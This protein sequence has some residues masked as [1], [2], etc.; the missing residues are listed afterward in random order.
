MEKIEKFETWTPFIF[1]RYPYLA[2]NEWKKKLLSLQEMKTSAA[3][4]LYLIDQVN[5][6][7]QTHQ[8]SSLR[9]NCKHFL[10][11]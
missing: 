5:A 6:H 8:R 1:I 4:T 10:F 11:I 7:N 9:Y 2:N 3:R